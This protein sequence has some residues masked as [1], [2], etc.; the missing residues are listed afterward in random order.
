[1][2][3]LVNERLFVYTEGMS[4]GVVDQ[5]R[6]AID[7]L[8]AAEIVGSSQREDVAA[9]W[10]EL[11]RL[12]AQ[13]A[14]RIAEFDRSVEWSVDGA[15]S[16]A[17]WLVAKARAGSGEAHHRVKGARQI[18]EMPVAAGAWESGAI[19]SRHVDALT[20]VRH[21][22]GADEY[23]AVFEPV[24]VEVAKTGRPEDV[25]SSGQQWRDALDSH[26]DR[27][28]ANRRDGKRSDR[29]RIDFSRSLH[30]VG[31][32]KGKF[33]VETTELV[34]TALSR[35]YQQLHAEH[36]ERPPDEQRADAFAAICRFYLDHQGR[37]ANRPHMIV[38]VDAATLAGEA[39]GTCET[40]SGY[41]ISPETARRLACD[42]IVQRI[43]IDAEGVP[44]D[45]G[46][47]ERTFTADQYRAIMI[48]DGGCRFPGCD[49]RPEQC[50]AHHALVFWEDGGLTDLANGLAVCRGRGHHRMI[51]EGGWSVEGDP[52]G[53]LTFLDPDGNGHGTTRPRNLPP[54]LP[55]RLGNEITHVRVRAD[56]LRVRIAEPCRAR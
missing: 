7:A 50:E 37:G 21:A 33:D 48:R 42:A 36:D 39:V 3:W 35:C 14:R 31:F 44:L 20:R 6:A 17:G 2:F 28:G 27:D 51:H 18:A 40:I 9:L 52:N 45:M 38:T 41:R 43:V 24:L 11:A 56:A 46:R 54:P 26:L 23:F 5:L 4:S 19:S 49:A 34:G 16:A 10:C 1:M 29:N 13:V 30:G 15:R 55:T 8:A 25:A 22:A 53:E 12:E 32:L 47:A